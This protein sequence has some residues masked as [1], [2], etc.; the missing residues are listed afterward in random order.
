[1]ISVYKQKDLTEARSFVYIKY[2]ISYAAG[3]SAAGAASGAFSAAG[4]GAAV[5]GAASADFSSTGVAEL[6]S[7][8]VATTSVVFTSVAFFSQEPHPQQ[9]GNIATKTTAHSS[10]I[11]FCIINNSSLGSYGFNDTR[12]FLFFFSTVFSGTCN[13]LS[14]IIAKTSSIVDTNLILRP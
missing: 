1:M 12:F 9:P 2:N 6:F 7:S 3:F 4:A 5:A 10:D 11:I 13:G 14:K 8:T